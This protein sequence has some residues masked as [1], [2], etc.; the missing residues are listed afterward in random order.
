M[1]G[2]YTKAGSFEIDW[3]GRKLP[4]DRY[5]DPVN[6]MLYRIWLPDGREI[7]MSK[8]S[9][10]EWWGFPELDILPE[11]GRQIDEWEL[12]RQLVK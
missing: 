7:R 6:K 3:K 5:A 12:K 11:A 1:E 2:N 10:G 9:K 8:N 4:V